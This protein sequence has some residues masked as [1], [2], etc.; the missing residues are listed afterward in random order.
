MPQLNEVDIVPIQSK[1]VPAMVRLAKENLPLRTN[2][3]DT[4]VKLTEQ[5]DAAL[6]KS[7]VVWVVARDAK[8]QKLVGY[9]LASALND[10]SSEEVRYTTATTAAIQDIAVAEEWGFVHQALTEHVV[11]QYAEIGYEQVFTYAAPD[12]AAGYTGS[13]VEFLPAGY[14]WVWAEPDLD[15]SDG[16]NQIFF[17]TGVGGA[18]TSI[19]RSS[20]GTMKTIGLSF[21]QFADGNSARHNAFTA[22]FD[23]LRALPVE[24][25]SRYST[26]LD[27]V[28]RFAQR[29]RD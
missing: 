5:S 12:V 27:S 15:L 11:A 17:N 26:A 8:T 4:F 1:D 25:Q 13:K 16:A 18:W 10:A 19:G 3:D 21:E 22:L 2:F 24:Q 7:G 28:A 20:N 29:Q 23:K 6:R 14:G 9:A